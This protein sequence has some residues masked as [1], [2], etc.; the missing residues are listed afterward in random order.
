MRPH[1]LS[2]HDFAALCSGK[3]PRVGAISRPLAQV[4]GVTIATGS[5]VNA[6]DL[7]VRALEV[8]TAEQAAVLNRIENLVL[9]AD[10]GSFDAEWRQFA[11]DNPNG[12]LDAPGFVEKVGRRR[13]ITDQF[14]AL[15]ARYDVLLPRL[16][17][18]GIVTSA[19]PSGE[20]ES[21]M[22]RLARAVGMSSTTVKVAAITAGTVGGLVLLGTVLL[23]E[24]RNR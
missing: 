20:S 24:R 1:D 18:A 10:W 12:A 13:M 3:I 7:Q 5:D 6:L 8:D 4:A 23:H 22:D 11:S 16:K 9:M 17:K 14:N 21:W 15:T 2:A 19:R